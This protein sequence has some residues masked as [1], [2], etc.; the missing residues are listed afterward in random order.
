VEVA[1]RAGAMLDKIVPDIQRT[2]E[3]VSE[4]NAASNEQNSGGEQINTS[5]LAPRISPK[6][7]EGASE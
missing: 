6:R 1:E 5:F 4:I 2:V 3:L 7:G